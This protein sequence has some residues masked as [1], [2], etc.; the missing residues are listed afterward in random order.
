MAHI[1]VSVV[2][3]L[4]DTYEVRLDTGDV[5]NTYRVELPNEDFERYSDGEEPIEMIKATFRFLL[6]REEPDE[7]LDEFRLRE[8][9]KIFPEFPHEIGDYV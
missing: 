1:N 8:V 4:P 6:E 7:I 2:S 3:D 5:E 9:E